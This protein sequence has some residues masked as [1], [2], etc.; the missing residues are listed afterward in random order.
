M[1]KARV[2][3]GGCSGSVTLKQLISLHRTVACFVYGHSST[4]FN[5]AHKLIDA[6]C[7][8]EYCSISKYTLGLP[9]ALIIRLVNVFADLASIIRL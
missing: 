2:R 9:P 4:H 6:S 5:C 3:C 7:D 1:P 8:R